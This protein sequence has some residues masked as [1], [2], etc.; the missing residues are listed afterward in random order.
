MV[1]QNGQRMR[2]AMHAA[3][4]AVVVASSPVAEACVLADPLL[5]PHEVDPAQSSDTTAPAAPQA[6]FTISRREIG[7]G[8]VTTDCDGKYAGVHV[9]VVGMDDATPQNKLG[10]ILT[11]AGGDVPK[12]YYG[13]GFDGMPYFQP[14][15]TF[16]LGFDYND[17][18]FAFDLEI[19]VIDLNGNISAPT[20]LHIDEHAGG[21]GCST[22]SSHSEWLLVPVLGLMLRRRRVASRRRSR[23]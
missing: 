15:G 18:D 21:G 3:L 23:C 7:G 9:D 2:L 4:V 14:D 8:C 16:V 10:Y 12:G 5:M 20:I 19:R 11:I 6:T 22:S 1:L 17:N 13:R